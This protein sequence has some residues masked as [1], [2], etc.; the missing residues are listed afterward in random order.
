[1]GFINHFEA[2]RRK[3]RSELFRDDVGCAHG[4]YLRFSLEAVTA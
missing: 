1:M 4:G 2:L 3:R